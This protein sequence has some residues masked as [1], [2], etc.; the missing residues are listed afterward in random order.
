MSSL[1][2]SYERWVRSEYKWLLPLLDTAR[3]LTLFLPG[4]FSDS[5]LRSE[6][7]QMPHTALQAQRSLAKLFPLTLSALLLA[8]A[9]SLHRAQP[10][11]CLS[12]L[13]PR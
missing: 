13:Y 3:N 2:Q 9:H 5:E 10:L 11:D 7:S 8:Y 4:R 12:R 1:K 6:G